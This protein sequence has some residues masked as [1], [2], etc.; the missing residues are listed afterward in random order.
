VAEGRLQRRLVAAQPAERE[1]GE[2]LGVQDVRDVWLGWTC[3]PNHTQDIT[4]HF[5]T[6]VAALAKH[7]SQ[8]AEGIAFFEEFMGEDAKRS[9]EKIGVE[10][11]EEFRMLELG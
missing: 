5:G 1:L 8:L 7:D 9:G 4:G 3:E 11:A 10:H 2:G 6:K